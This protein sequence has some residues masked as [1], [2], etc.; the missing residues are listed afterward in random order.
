MCHWR[1]A[2]R[3]VYV[4]LVCLVFITCGAQI[5][6]I[7][8]PMPLWCALVRSCLCLNCSMKLSCRRCNVITITPERTRRARARH[9]QTMTSSTRISEFTVCK[10]KTENLKCIFPFLKSVRMNSVFYRHFSPTRRTYILTHFQNCLKL[11]KSI[12]FRS[13]CVRRY[14]VLAGQH[15]ETWVWPK[16]YSTASAV[17]FRRSY[18]I[19]MGDGMVSV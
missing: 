15:R 8:S 11:F 13:N 1:P 19:E 17:A 10:C 14:V 6:S 9:K 12:V 16:M 4:V 5:V 3:V 2:R 18:H 7:S